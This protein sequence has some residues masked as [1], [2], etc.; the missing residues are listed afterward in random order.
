MGGR[1]KSEQPKNCTPSPARPNGTHLCLS[2]GRL[3]QESEGFRAMH[4]AQ[5]DLT[6]AVPRDPIFETKEGRE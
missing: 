3:K 2:V 4:T 6:H 1:E 5:R